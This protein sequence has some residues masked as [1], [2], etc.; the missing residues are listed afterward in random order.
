MVF[1]VAQSYLYSRPI[2][3]V[4]MDDIIASHLKTYGEKE[5]TES[6]RKALSEQFA[7]SLDRVIQQVAR[8]TARHAA[9]V[10]RG[11]LECA[12]LHRLCEIRDPEVFRW[13]VSPFP[14]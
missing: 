2:A 6:Q 11:G 5:L 4:R 3:V 8:A 1:T 9:G 10:P 12:G 7:R 14:S 13:R